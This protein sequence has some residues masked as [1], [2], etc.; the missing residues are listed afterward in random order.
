MAAWFVAF[1]DI[2]VNSKNKCFNKSINNNKVFFSKYVIRKGHK[3]HITICFKGG[4]C[5]KE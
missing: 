2:Q 4:N 1:E 3:S 5:K